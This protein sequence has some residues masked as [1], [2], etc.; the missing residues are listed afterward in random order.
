MTTGTCDNR[1]SR[2]D[3]GIALVSEVWAQ[4]CRAAGRVVAE[5]RAV[6]SLKSHKAGRKSGAYRLEGI[7]PRVVAK[8][9][10]RD[11]AL[12]EQLVYQ[13]ILP[14]ISLS[15]IAFH[16]CIDDP[17]DSGYCWLFVDDAGS[18]KPTECHRSLVAQWLARLHTRSAPLAD[19]VSLPERGPAH[20]LQHL[21]TAHGNV[22][23]C[24]E[25]VPLSTTER[26]ALD[27]LRRLLDRIE[28][29]WDAIC[30][31]CSALP[32]T[33]VHGDVARKNCRLRDAA[34]DGPS[35]VMLDWETAGWG[36]PA[37]DLRAWARPA[38]KTLGGWGGTV[39][40]DDY[41]AAVAGVWP[42]VTRRD[43][44]RH[45]AMG[46]VFRLVAGIRWASES[47]NVGGASQ[48]VVKLTLLSDALST[49]EKVG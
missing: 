49:C 47:L 26:A 38:K 28:S 41:A 45:S 14:A 19:V 35:I 36:P 20:Y 17:T 27:E 23:C 39:A 6:V 46:T 18:V 10:R 7:E 34:P 43:V 32:R 3:I 40:L 37:A 12:V 9:C 33:L 2:P 29:R 25:T 48:G 5:P 24:I 21:R 31:P 8:R 42:S 4:L 15:A 30:R 13:Q 11:T 44:Q 22:E 16:G 1:A